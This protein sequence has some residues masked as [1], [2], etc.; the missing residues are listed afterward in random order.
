MAGTS[1]AS[2]A[3]CAA[4]GVER[5]ACGGAHDGDALL[6]PCPV[7]AATGDHRHMCAQLCYY[8]HY[9]PARRLEALRR[10][11]AAAGVA[12]ATASLAGW[13]VELRERQQRRGAQHVPWEVIFVDGNAE[14][15][16]T[17]G[18]ALR[19]LG[20]EVQPRRGA[21][22]PRE[23]PI[24]DAAA[25]S[26]GEGKGGRAG[27]RSDD[28]CSDAG[29]QRT[30][31]RRRRASVVASPGQSRFFAP[32]PPPP[33]TPED[34]MASP[35]AAGEAQHTATG[36]PRRLLDQLEGALLS[37]AAMASRASGGSPRGL[38]RVPGW[39]APHSPYGL[40]EELYRRE[41]WKLLVS[42]MLLNCTTRLQ[43]DRVLPALFNRYPTARALA[44][45]P[46]AAELERLLAPL[47]LQRR[48]S[49]SLLRFSR[50]YTEKPWADV[51][52]L[53]GV[54]KYAADAYAIFILGRWRETRPDDH[55]LN[56]YHRFLESALG[57]GSEAAA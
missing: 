13:R 9:E 21:R 36:T 41:P 5:V 45:A 38:A 30:P 19:A 6:A 11:A 25:D 54:G 48:R 10:A 49:K 50:E 57:D 8:R 4:R 26:D 28:G 15:Y 37:C 24:A 16:R 56:F 35:D 42:C 51:M 12:N 17:E 29:A 44:A 32:A 7:L 31:K 33:L 53:H 47:G 2:P 27:R 14:E 40:L 34:G 43:V 23:P 18:A 1:P 52:E 22:V 39:L 3:T 46:D 55:A 20:A